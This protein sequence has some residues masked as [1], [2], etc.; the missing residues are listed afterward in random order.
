MKKWLYHLSYSRLFANCTLKDVAFWLSRSLLTSHIPFYCCFVKAIETH[1]P[2]W[3][4]PSVDIT[5]AQILRLGL[6]L[7]HQDS[8]AWGQR[9]GRNG[10]LAGTSQPATVTSCVSTEMQTTKRCVLSPVD[11]HVSGGAIL[12]TPPAK[13]RETGKRM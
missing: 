3:L 4:F 5:A 2:K 9:S 7:H 6:R 13:N 10:Q 11:R 8:R 1:I 12:S